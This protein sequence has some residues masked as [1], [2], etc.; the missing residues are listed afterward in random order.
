MKM[1]LFL[2]QAI[3]IAATGCSP[4]LSISVT[5]KFPF[6]KAEKKSQQLSYEPVKLDSSFQFMEVAR[7]NEKKPALQIEGSYQLINLLEFP[8]SPNE[9]GSSRPYD[10]S[11][12]ANSGLVEWGTAKHSAYKLFQHAH[13]LKMY[14]DENG[15]NNWV[16]FM[17]DMEVL[18]GKKRFFV[19]DLQDM[20]ILHSGLVAHGSG[21]ITLSREKVFS[22]LPGSGCTSLGIYKIG[23]PYEGEYGLAY[24]LYG[25]DETNSNALK[26]NVVLHSMGCVPD[27]EI[28]G[29][30]CQSEGCP[31][32]S[33]AFLEYLQQILDNSKK[34]VLL[35]IYE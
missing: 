10:P 2:F 31:S 11:D 19:Y 17:I 32:V 21:G 35:W 9:K 12:L 25:L 6:I 20:K 22:N 26:R 29:L 23:T 4:K 34:P 30:L 18:S 33:P 3:L 1:K 13:Q 7:S 8:E 14:A 28:D 15:Y 16:A 5:K 24:K 27:K